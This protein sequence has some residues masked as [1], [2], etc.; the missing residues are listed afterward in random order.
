MEAVD[1]YKSRS[2]WASWWKL[3]D[4]IRR[5]YFTREERTFITRYG[6]RLDELACFRVE[7]KTDRERQ[8]LRVC[9]GDEEPSTPNHRTWLLVQ[10]VCRYHR[11]VARAA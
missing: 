4:A 8:F 2:V 1:A 11:A 6:A 9:S 10:L 7:P 5:R 3:D